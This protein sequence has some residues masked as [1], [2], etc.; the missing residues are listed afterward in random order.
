MLLGAVFRL[1][2]SDK[3]II[4]ITSDT[5]HWIK[6]FIVGNR[7]VYEIIVASHI[8]RKQWSNCI[9]EKAT[10]QVGPKILALWLVSNGS[11][12][13]CI[14]QNSIKSDPEV[15]K[16]ISCSNQLNTK[17][18]LLIH[19]KIAKF[20]ENLRLKSSKKVIYPAINVKC[21]KAF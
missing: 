3:S 1:C 15:I 18:H 13:A 14:G 5:C 11:R 20:N 6:H 2:N 7:H 12:L 19:I 10:N 21:Q 8:L 16:H 17:F 9:Q 4:Q